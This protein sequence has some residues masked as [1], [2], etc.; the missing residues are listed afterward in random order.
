MRKIIIFLAIAVL[1][2]VCGIGSCS[3]RRNSSSQNTQ[4]ADLQKQISDLQTEAEKIADMQKN[5]QQQPAAEGAK[6]TR[7]T[8]PIERP[9]TSVAMPKSESRPLIEIRDDIRYL[10]DKI[11]STGTDLAIARVN[12][13]A[14]NAVPRRNIIRR[15][16]IASTERKI[17][18]MKSELADLV[19]ELQRAE[20]P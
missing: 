18:D 15:A 11:R 6:F 2:V 12:A 10:Q 20:K 19:A 9:A 13:R 8:A 1:L 4:I 5:L 7:T 3:C 17:Q 14:D 16:D